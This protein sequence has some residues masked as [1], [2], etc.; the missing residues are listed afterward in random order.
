MMLKSRYGAGIFFVFLRTPR[1]GQA[2]DIRFYNRL[3][4]FVFACTT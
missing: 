1:F 4:N 2:T 3:T